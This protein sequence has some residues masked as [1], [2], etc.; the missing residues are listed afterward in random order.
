MFLIIACYALLA[1]TFT[2]AKSV[3]MYGKPFFTIGFRMTLSGVALLGYRALATTNGLAIKREDYAVFFRIALFHI[4]IA[5]MLEFWALQYISSAKTCLLYAL[6]PFIAAFL[7]N[8]LLREYLSPIKKISLVFGFFSIVPVLIHQ[9][10]NRSMIFLTFPE[11]ILLCA[12]V[13]AAY[14]WFDVQKMMNKGYSLI[15]I[16]GFAMFFG[17]IGALITSCLVEGW[18]SSPVSNWASFLQIIVV[19]MFVS[20]VIFYNLFGML[21]K[22]YSITFVTFIGFLTPLFASLFGWLFLGET[23]TWH[24]AL[25]LVLLICSLALFSSK[26]S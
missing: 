11:C 14:A 19:L 12:I 20:N 23:I 1:S 5:F 10:F 25:S 8:L 16:N 21:L 2:L 26:K 17:G 24:Y 6:T 9:G 15:L 13:S 18:A 22:R 7:A 3:L 4:Y